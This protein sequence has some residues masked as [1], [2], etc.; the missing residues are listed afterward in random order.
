MLEYW[1]EYLLSSGN[2]KDSCKYLLYAL[3]YMSYVEDD[4]DKTKIGKLPI[5]GIEKMEE[6][7]LLN[8][9]LA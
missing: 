7:K 1:S 2:K 5:N 9:F 8:I 4:N 3:F 6:N